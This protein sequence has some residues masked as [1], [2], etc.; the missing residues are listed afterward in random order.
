MKSRYTQLI[1]SGIV[2]CLL[3]FNINLIFR[4]QRDKNRLATVVQNMQRLN[5]VEF[6]FQDSKEIT[7]KRF[8]Y[9]Q[10]NIGNVYIYTGSDKNAHMPIRSITERP[11]LVLGLSQNMC[12]PCIE[13]VLAD[14][15]EFFPD[16]ETNENII[17]IADI[18]QR[19]K[20]NYHNKKVVS[21]QQK[22]DFHLYEIENP[23][24]FILDKDLVVKLLLITDKTSPEL[25]KEYL[26]IIRERY[27]NL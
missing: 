1:L 22:D 16:Y 21:F 2:V 15:N 18:E 20:D 23:Y 17:Y 6:M 8:K 7:A 9:E 19:F 12:R 14:L 13:G 5:N 27:P 26:K 4:Q 25:T 10:F 11:K 24:F 3:L